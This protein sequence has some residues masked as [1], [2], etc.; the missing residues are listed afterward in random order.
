MPKAAML[1][2]KQMRPSFAKPSIRMR[3]HCHKGCAGMTI[4]CSCA[5]EANPQQAANAS[6]MDSEVAE[7][8]VF[9]LV[10]VLTYNCSIQRVLCN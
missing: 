5:P 3:Q 4:R 10:S 6:Q 1:I 8:G 2:A 7:S 9:H